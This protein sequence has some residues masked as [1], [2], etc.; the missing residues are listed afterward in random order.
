M[1]NHAFVEAEDAKQKGQ[2]TLHFSDPQ[3]PELPFESESWDGCVPYTFPIEKP[4][5]NH[6]EFR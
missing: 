1:D 3:Q 2:L 6:I 5:M 4:D